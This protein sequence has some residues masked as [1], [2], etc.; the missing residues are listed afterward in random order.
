MVEVQEQ[1]ELRGVLQGG[2]SHTLKVGVS[3]EPV[4]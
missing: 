4:A 1:Q 3:V 2:Q